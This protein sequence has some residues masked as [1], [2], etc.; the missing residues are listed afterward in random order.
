M[1]LSWKRAIIM[2]APAKASPVTVSAA[3]SGWR[4]I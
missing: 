1:E 2:M 4:S 3:R